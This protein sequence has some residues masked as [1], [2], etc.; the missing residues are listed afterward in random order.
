MYHLNNNPNI[1]TV[2]KLGE[3]LTDDSI[4]PHSSNKCDNLM[5]VINLG[6]DHLYFD[7]DIVLLE[8]L[9]ERLKKLI[10]EHLS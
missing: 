7:I 4:N 5:S 10:N 1:D 6:N 9:V 3:N 8:Q 2:N